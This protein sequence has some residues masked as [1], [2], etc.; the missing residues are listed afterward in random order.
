MGDDLE[1]ALNMLPEEFQAAERN[2]PFLREK[3]RYLLKHVGCT[4]SWLAQQMGWKGPSRVTQ[5]FTAGSIPAHQYHRWCKVLGIRPE[6]LAIP[7]YEEFV[8]VMESVRATRAGQRW[9]TFVDEHGYKGVKIGFPDNE[10]S[11]PGTQITYLKGLYQ[12][13][14]AAAENH[15]ELPV[16]RKGE[17]IFFELAHSAVTLPDD[18]SLETYLLLLDSREDPALRYL[19]PTR[20][21]DKP[22]STAKSYF[23]TSEDGQGYRLGAPYGSHTIYIILASTNL[24][25]DIAEFFQ[26][27]RAGI[28]ADKLAEWLQENSEIKF[29]LH[30]SEFFVSPR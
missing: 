9:K 25:K 27:G 28:G 22:D 26:I 20:Q 2:I 17:R 19:S 3:T 1:D 4:Q 5:V 12:S 13:D 18:V 30:V 6:E 24:P 23:F 10:K 16:V 14:E 8:R 21:P 7:T 11:I 29:S 15:I